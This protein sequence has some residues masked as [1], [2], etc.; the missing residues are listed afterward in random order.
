MPKAD[1]HG[2]HKFGQNFL[3]AIK[4]EKCDFTGRYILLDL[5]GFNVEDE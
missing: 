4:N 3:D 1:R 2:I 5:G